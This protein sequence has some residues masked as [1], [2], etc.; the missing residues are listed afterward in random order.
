MRPWTPG[1]R[2]SA[3]LGGLS[4]WSPVAQ[5]FV[6]FQNVSVGV[7]NEANTASAVAHRHGAFAD[8][9]ALAF[10]PCHQIVHAVY[11]EG[12]MCVAWPFFRRIEQDIAFARRRAVIDQVEP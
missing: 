7:S 9:D 12:S 1:T 2:R 6:E 10:K 5:N 3:R 4:L 8:R 11:D